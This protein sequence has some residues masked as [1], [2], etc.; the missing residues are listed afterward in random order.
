MKNIDFSKPGGFPLTQDQLGYMQ[1]AYTEALVALASVGGTG[2][3]VISGV[4]MT[5]TTVSVPT[6]TYSVTAGWVLYNGEMIRVSAGSITID[7]SIA[8]LGFAIIR[9]S[10]P[11]TYNDGASYN[12]VN[13]VT[14]ALTSNPIGASDDANYFS[15]G[16]LRKYGRETTANTLAVSTLPADGGVSGNIYYRKNFL[17]NTLQLS[18]F[19]GCANVQNFASV[20]APQ[21]YVLGTLPIGY[22]PAANL[23]FL[24]LPISVYRLKDDLDISWLDTVVCSI[25]STGVLAAKFIRPQAS[26]VSYAFAFNVLL[27]LD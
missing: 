20:S 15:V 17:N 18:A 9:A 23:Y 5:R 24:G 8:T 19:I 27:P 10:A 21:F 1:S 7:A 22:R 6:Y 12:V 14:C 4:E 11:L 3:I 26:I 2:P 25:S 16:S 13:D